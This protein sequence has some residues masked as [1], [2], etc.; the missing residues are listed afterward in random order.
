MKKIVQFVFMLSTFSLFLGCGASR[1]N[2]DADE[3]ANF[4]NY[5]TFRFTDSDVQT[6]PNPLYHS[7]LIDNTIHAQIA[8]ELDARGIQEDERHPDMLI[9]YHTYTERKRQSINNYYPMMYGGYGWGFYPWGVGAYPYGYWNGY[10]RTYVYTE[11]TLI[12][13]AIDS[14]TNQ[15]IWRGSISDAI[16]T[17]NDLHRKAIKAV[18]MI[19]KKFPVQS[20]KSFQRDSKPIARKN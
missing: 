18:Q 9:A 3:K 11:G 17:P 14:K 7:S 6:G 15:L 8:M 5:H 12:I 1:V 2:T 16:N 4:N 10:N 13:D 19:F 20:G